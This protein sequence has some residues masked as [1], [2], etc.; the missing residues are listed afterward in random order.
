MAL[1][2]CDRHVSESDVQLL[3]EKNASRQSKRLVRSRADLAGFGSGGSS[4][5]EAG[6]AVSGIHSNFTAA[7]MVDRQDLHRLPYPWEEHANL[8]LLCKADAVRCSLQTCQMQF[9]GFRL[10][11]MGSFSRIEDKRGAVLQLYGP[12]NTVYCASYDRAM[13]SYLACLKVGLP[14]SLP[15]SHFRPNHCA[16]PTRAG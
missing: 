1:K 11:P 8:K 15:C 7:L 9:T 14:A 10:L 16:H 2:H 13:V 5:H 3:S 12:V 4:L 6:N